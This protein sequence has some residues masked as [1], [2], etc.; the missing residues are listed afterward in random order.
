MT[1]RDPTPFDFGQWAAR[2]AGLKVDAVLIGVTGILAVY[3]ARVRTT[4]RA[5]SWAARI[6]SVAVARQPA[7]GPHVIARMSPDLNWENA[8]Q[9]HPEVFRRD[10]HGNVVHHN[11]RLNSATGYI[12]PRDM[13]VVR[14]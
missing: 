5:R 8:V 11:V 12:T 6:S 13:R 7:K 3:P 9:A 2:W 4:V 10:A 1:G 14:Q